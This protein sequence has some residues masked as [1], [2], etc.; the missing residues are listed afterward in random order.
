MDKLEKQLAAIAAAILLAIVVIGYGASSPASNSSIADALTA[1]PKLKS[2]V[3]AKNESGRAIVKMD[4]VMLRVS[5]PK[6]GEA[7]VADQAR[8]IK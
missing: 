3:Q 5:C 4:I 6:D 7:T 1:C 8:A 2:E